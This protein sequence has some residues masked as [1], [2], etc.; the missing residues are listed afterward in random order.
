MEAE[1]ETYRHPATQRQEGRPR[2]RGFLCSCARHGVLQWILNGRTN[3][4]ANNTTSYCHSSQ[5]G[6]P[7]CIQ[8]ACFPV[9]TFRECPSATTTFVCRRGLRSRKIF[10]TPEE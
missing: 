8:N 3:V 7:V 4:T 5:Q 10:P 2:T 9:S 1:E 6:G